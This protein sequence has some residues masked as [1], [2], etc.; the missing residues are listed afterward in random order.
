MTIAKALE[1][2]CRQQIRFHNRE[3]SELL[4]LRAKLWGEVEREIERLVDERLKDH[5]KQQQSTLRRQNR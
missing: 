5:G 2:A 4:A 1:E 3:D